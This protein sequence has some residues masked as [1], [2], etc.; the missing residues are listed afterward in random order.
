MKKIIL[1]IYFFLFASLQLFAQNYDYGWITDLHIGY[2]NADVNLENVVHDINQRDSIKFVVVTGDIAEK[3][4]NNQLETAKKILDS[5]KVHYYII[6]GNHDTKWSESGCQE[7]N[8]LWK[9]NK[10]A[11]IYDST[12]HI[13]LNSGIPWR[14]G[15]G[16]IAP[17]DLKWL[18]SVVTKTPQNIPLIFYVHHPLDNTID[19]WFKVTNILRKHKIKAVLVGHGHANKLMNFNGIPGA[20]ERS[21]LSKNQKSWGYTLVENKPDSLLFYEVNTDTIPHHW[22]TIVQDTDPIPF[23][24]STQFINYAGD[25]LKTKPGIFTKVLWQK[26]LNTTFTT[27]LETSYDKL[28]AATESGVVYCYNLKGKLL[29]KYKTGETIFSKPLISNGMVVVATIQGDLMAL[30]E[31]TGRIVQAIGIGEPL[32]SQLVTVQVNYNG[33]RTTGIITGTSKGNLYC[34]AI[35]TF[36]MIWEN[37]SAKGMIQTKP[38]VINKRIIY[39]AWDGFLYCV[40]SQSGMLNWKWTEN[41]NFYYSPAACTP[42]SDGQYVYVTTPDK[43]VS[44]VDLLLGVT[45]WHK[46]N[47]NSWESIGISKNKKNLFI[48][49]LKD[50]FYVLSTR[51]GRLIKRIK[52][53]FDL[54]T[55][56]NIPIEWKD[57]I[58]FASKNGKIYLINKHYDWQPLFF[59][60]TARVL[61]IEHIRNNMFA[62]SNMDGKIVV[63]ELRTLDK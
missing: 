26:N 50:D 48:K 16:H 40:D 36:E 25:S 10:F 57:N 62:V 4:E 13:G 31:N 12:E 29:W 17:E 22:G 37:S 27:S 18:D 51:K 59:L 34:Y 21:S 60:G 2:P 38:L 7:F 14:G 61:N 8:T 55:T 6:P 43:S 56:P 32:T 30:D 23:V 42:V 44:E 5:L 19:N 45:S 46:K 39:G 35:N 54:D 1:T 52:I 53:G 20:M 33:Q 24:D 9:D 47:A 63:L 3:G 11:F 58:L 49:G 28:V 15:G 41:K